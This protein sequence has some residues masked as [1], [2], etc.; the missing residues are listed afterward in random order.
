MAEE[1][2]HDPN[3][4]GTQKEVALVAA[5]EGFQVRIDICEG[6]RDLEG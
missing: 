1:K 2:M 4:Y 5:Q 3:M 6:R